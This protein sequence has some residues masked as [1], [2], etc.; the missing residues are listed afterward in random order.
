MVLPRMAKGCQYQ[1]H[2]STEDERE[3][4]RSNVGKISRQPERF[5]AAAQQLRIKGTGNPYCFAY[6]RGMHV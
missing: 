1:S 4:H 6:K 2:N 5:R 3:G